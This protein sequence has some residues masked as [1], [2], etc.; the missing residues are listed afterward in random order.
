MGIPRAVP[1]SDSSSTGGAASLKPDIA[2]CKTVPT[3]K[4]QAG[5]RVV[6][7]GD[8]EKSG[9]YGYTVSADYGSCYDSSD[10]LPD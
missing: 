9:K 5:K 1:A 10:R 8:P 4:I 2:P 3:M 7:I 6:F